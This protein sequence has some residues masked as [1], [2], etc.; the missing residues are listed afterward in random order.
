M[1]LETVFTFLLALLIMAVLLWIMGNLEK[2]VFVV[3]HHMGNGIY[4]E[5][6]YYHSL[7]KALA[8]V[9]YLREY[10]ARELKLMGIRDITIVEKIVH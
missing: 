4:Y 2:K 1:S 7:T 3:R 10:R 5:A 6:C 9:R 8:R